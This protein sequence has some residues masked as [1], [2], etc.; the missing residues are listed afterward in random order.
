MIS[1]YEVLALANNQQD[2][3]LLGK[4]V[5]LTGHEVVVKPNTIIKDRDTDEPLIIFGKLKKSY[6]E[7]KSFLRVIKYQNN[8]RVTRLKTHYENERSS[9]ISFGFKPQNA[10]YSVAAG[11]CQ[12]NATAPKWYQKLI[13]LGVDLQSIYE[14]TNPERFERQKKIITETIKPHWVIENTIFTQGI[15]NNTNNLDYHYDRGNFENCWSC[16]AT[17]YINTV[18][19]ELLVPSLNI[20]L[21]L[22]DSCFVLFDGQSLIHGVAPIKKLSKNAYRFSIVYYALKKMALCDSFEDEINKMRQIDMKKHM[23]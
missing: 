9:D 3:S 18:G 8:R 20:A 17:F 12:F 15:I 22:E 13:S 4:P 14:L 1:N 21:K 5:S 6:S 11:A 10:I 2:E 23:K 19:G 7:V 16:M